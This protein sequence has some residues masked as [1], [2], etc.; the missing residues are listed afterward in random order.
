[1]I[2]RDLL[3]KTSRVLPR[4]LEREA[5]LADFRYMMRVAAKETDIDQINEIKMVFYSIIDKIDNGVYPP[6]PVEQK[7]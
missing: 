1:M 6:F 5:K 3:K 4:K 2:Y 7:V